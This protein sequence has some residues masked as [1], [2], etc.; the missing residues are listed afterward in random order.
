MLEQAFEA[1][2]HVVV[3][4]GWADTILKSILDNEETS[5]QVGDC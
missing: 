3:G 2:D 4:D 1:C 5:L